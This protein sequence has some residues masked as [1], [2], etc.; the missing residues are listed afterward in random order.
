MDHLYRATVGIKYIDKEFEREVPWD[1]KR[2]PL[3]PST[4][5]DQICEFIY[6]TFRK[7]GAFQTIIS[8][9]ELVSKRVPCHC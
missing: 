2:T 1:S 6:Q 4:P 5:D 7:P 9:R 8:F 3:L